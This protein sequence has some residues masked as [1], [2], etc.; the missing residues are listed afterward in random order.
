MSMGL[1]IKGETVKLVVKT[2]TGT[3][4]FG[5]P[6]YT[7]EEV[8]VDNVLVGEPSSEDVTAE[9][10]LTGK[11]IAYTLGI[12]KGDTHTWYDTFVMVRGERYRTIGRPVYGTPENMPLAWGGKVSVERYGGED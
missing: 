5:A 1:M 10:N 8:T 7:E 9:N 4:A 3:D 6:V 2:K 11:R 12:P